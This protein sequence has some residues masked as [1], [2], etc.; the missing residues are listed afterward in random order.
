VSE[1]SAN[2]QAGIDQLKGLVQGGSYQT[3]SSATSHALVKDAL[4][5]ED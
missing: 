2:R 4:S 1:S 5:A 3:S